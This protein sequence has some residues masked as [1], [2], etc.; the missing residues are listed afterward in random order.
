MSS[1]HWYRCDVRV[2]ERHGL[3]PDALGRGKAVYDELRTELMAG[4]YL[5]ILEQARRT[6]TAESAM[7]VITYKSAKYTIE[8]PL[9]L[10][11]AL[12]DGQPE[13]L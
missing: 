4:Q 6:P 11:A 9:Q 1:P 10:G 13:V 2:P 12:A 3:P 7:R 8:R 5:D